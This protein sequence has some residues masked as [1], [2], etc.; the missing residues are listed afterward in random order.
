MK[1]KTKNAKLMSQCHKSIR[2]PV[3]MRIRACDKGYG[4]P[5][6]TMSQCHKKSVMRKEEAHCGSNE[7]KT[8]LG[9]FPHIEKS[10]EVK[11][12]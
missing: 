5:C 11:A 2:N 6:H 4:K 12:I 3:N 7:G 1:T 10:L 8:P 9:V